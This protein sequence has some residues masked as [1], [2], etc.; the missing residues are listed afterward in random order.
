MPATSCEAASISILRSRTPGFEPKTVRARSRVS[1][2]CDFGGSVGDGFGE[3][4]AAVSFDVSF[5]TVGACDGAFFRIS[6][7]C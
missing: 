6:T 2:F 3:A 5:E 7:Y 4:G 1:S